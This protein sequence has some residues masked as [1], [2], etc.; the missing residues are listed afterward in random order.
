MKM[1]AQETKFY[2]QLSKLVLNYSKLKTIR[3]INR[4]FEFMQAENQHSFCSLLMAVHYGTQ[5]QVNEIQELI[6]K[7]NRKPAPNPSYMKRIKITSN[8]Y[9]LHQKA[10]N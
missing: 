7:Q 9:K 5:E 2:N 10:L 1:T 3:G 4:R 6:I 8:F